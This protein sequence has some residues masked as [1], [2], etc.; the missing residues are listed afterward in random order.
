MWLLTLEPTCGY[1]RRWDWRWLTMARES[2]RGR[3]PAPQ[4]N[5]PL[6]KRVYDIER[7]QGQLGRD[8]RKLKDTLNIKDNSISEINDWVGKHVLVTTVSGKTCYGILKWFDRYSYGVQP[9]DFHAEGVRIFQKGNVETI[10]PGRE[11]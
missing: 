1:R 2:R 3:A 5:S 8:V 6:R 10:E 7:F 4:Q 9:D 11:E